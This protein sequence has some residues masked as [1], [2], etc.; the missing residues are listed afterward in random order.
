MKDI[1]THALPVNIG[2]ANKFNQYIS[3]GIATRIMP[4]IGLVLN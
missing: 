4:T 2:L 3:I 1:K